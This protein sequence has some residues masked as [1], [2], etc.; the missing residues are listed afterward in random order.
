[1]SHSALPVRRWR[2][3]PAFSLI[4]LLIVIVIAGILVGISSNSIGEQIRRDRVMRSATVVQGL[5]SEATQIA[6]RRRVPVNITLTSGALR[7]TDRSSGTVIKRRDFGP[8]FDLR[9]TLA[10]N[11]SG[12]VTVFPN[13]RASAALTVTVSGIGISHT[14]TR[15]ATGIVRLQ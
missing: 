4:E 15:T 11:P 1:M 6:V 14:V 7:I 8:V 5:L 12:G 9:A 3:R 10:F 2:S 13:G